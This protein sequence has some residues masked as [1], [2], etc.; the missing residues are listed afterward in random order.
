M[1]KRSVIAEIIRTLIDQAKDHIQ[2]IQEHVSDFEESEDC[3]LFEAEE[4]LE[5]VQR[6]AAAC[7]GICDVAN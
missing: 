4:K 2:E 6:I 5:A 3:D 7:A 1:I